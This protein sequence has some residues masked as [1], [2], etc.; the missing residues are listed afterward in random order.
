MELP[1]MNVE[2]KTGLMKEINMKKLDGVGRGSSW[3][4]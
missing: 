2:T 4:N 1:I 3:P